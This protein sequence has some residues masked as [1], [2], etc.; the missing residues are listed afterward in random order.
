MDV[1]IKIRVKGTK[2]KIQR[3]HNLMFW[4]DTDWPFVSQT[5]R[6]ASVKTAVCT[7][8]GGRV[9][10]TPMINPGD[11]KK[12]G[13]QAGVKVKIDR[14]ALAGKCFKMG[15]VEKFEYIKVDQNA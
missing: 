3:W 11:I 8:C 1:H 14:Y 5:I 15:E 9:Y 12:L 6:A 13:E 7:K 4:V 2:E 10:K